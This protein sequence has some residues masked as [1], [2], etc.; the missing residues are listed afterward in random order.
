VRV[1]AE[2]LIEGMRTDAA[3]QARLVEGSF[4]F[5]GRFG[6]GEVEEGSG[7]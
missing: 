5:G 3:L 2:L 1:T 6:G 7:R 4:Q